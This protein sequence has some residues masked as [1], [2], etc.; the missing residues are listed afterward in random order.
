[1][2]T[3]L[4]CRGVQCPDLV[5]DHQARAGRI[6]PDRQDT[7]LSTERR[8]E[9]VRDPAILMQGRNAQ[10]QAPVRL[11]TYLHFDSC[12]IDVVR[13]Y[14]GVIL[15]I[16]ILDNKIIGRQIPRRLAAMLAVDPSASQRITRKPP[17]SS[18]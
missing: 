12:R 9:A 7:G 15:L 17:S 6:R 3:V 13:R 10:P 5:T 1:M 11:M 8:F 16:M 18:G 4:D 14:T 2:N